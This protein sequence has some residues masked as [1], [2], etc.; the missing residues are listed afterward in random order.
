MKNLKKMAMAACALIGLSLH[1]Q[2]SRADNVWVNVTHL[3][4]NP[5]YATNA[6]TGWTK[7]G[8]GTVACD[9]QTYT[10]KGGT[11]NVSQTLTNVPKG[12]Y[13]V[14]VNAFHRLRAADENNYSTDKDKAATSN[15]YVNTQRKSIKNIY[16]ESL[17]E[18]YHN[19]CWGH[20][21]RGW[22][23]WGGTTYYYP[24]NTESASYMLHS[25][26]YLN[27]ME[28]T[29]R[30]NGNLKIGISNTSSNSGNWT[31]FT[32][33]Q[34]EY[35][36]EV[37]TEG[38]SEV[39][40]N[41]IQSANTDLYMDPSGNYGGWVEI[42]NPTDHF[43]EMK[44]C[45]L[46]DEPGQLKKARIERSC[47]IAPQG[48]AVLWF[49][50]HDQY[51]RSQVNMKLDAD[52]GT[53]YL[54]DEDGTLITSQTY[55]EAISRCS[56]GRT[57]D[58]GQEWGWSATPTPAA[59][60]TG[61]LFSETRLAPP[62]VNHASQIFSGKLQ[63]SVTIPEG[64]VLR[65]TTDGSTP[66]ATHGQ[67]S[68]NGQFSVSSTSIYRFC[69]TGDG[70][71][72]SPVVTRTFLLKDKDFSLPVLSVVSS[73]D[74]LYGDAYGILTKGNGNGRPGYGQSSPCN[75]NMDWERPAHFEYFNEDGTCA[76]SQEVGMTR[77]GG[78]SRAWTPYSFKL[79]AN[80][81]YEHQN[82]MPYDFFPTQKP[83]L[84]HKTLQIRNSGNDAQIYG[85]FGGRIKDAALQQ[86]VMTSG[87]YL[88][89]Q[90]YQPVMHYINGKYMGV[91]NMREPNNKHY[92][93]A[94]YGLDDD[95]IDQFE[96]CADSGYVQ[97]CGTKER[98]NQWYELA[99]HASDPDTYLQIKERVDIDAF[100]N[101]MAVELYLGGDDWPHNNIKG[102]C[103]RTEG[104]KWKFIL[105][106]LDHAFNSSTPISRLYN[107]RKHTFASLYG[108]DGD[109][110]DITGQQQT[111][112]IE[113]ATIFFN[114]LRNADFR[115]QFIDTFCLVAGS[116][117]EPGRVKEIVTDLARRV[118]KPM[119]IANGYN[120]TNGPWTTANAVISKLSNRA[121]TMISHLKSYSG[122][123]LSTVTARTVKLGSNL[124]L[125]RLYVNDLPVP[126][127]KFNGKLFPPYTLRA[128]A[129]EGYRFMGWQESTGNVV[130]TEEVY[131]PATT[132]NLSLTATYVRLTEEEYLAEKG[133]APAPVVINEISAANS[134]YIN[135]Y[136]KK[137]DWI[138]LYNTT[139]E[140][141]DL[142]GMYLT[143]KTDNP[144]KY[145][146]S[147]K[148]AEGNTICSTLLPAHGY[149]VIWCSKREGVSQLHANF[150]LENEEG[151]M[152][153]IQDE[154]GTW[155]DSLSYGL[156]QG[157]QTMG[158]YPDGGEQTYL[159]VKP[160]I[161]ASNTLTSL[162]TPW[163][164]QPGDGLDGIR[165]VACANGLHLSY[166][167]QTLR[168]RSEDNPDITIHVCN[169]MGQTV[170]LQEK[171]L[172]GMTETTLSTYN[173][174]IGTYIAKVTDKEGNESSI[175][176]RKE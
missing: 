70:A 42:Y 140:D 26:M 89:C 3:L 129:P 118:E 44:G 80:K 51:A 173:L 18:N 133:H 175:K 68:A 37:T 16:S 9:F 145:R 128:S 104:G 90:A 69:L 155:A 152:V 58:G 122:M 50:N 138:E 141:I 7:T 113:I 126:T 123:K 8:T 164:E 95:E 23:G 67:T 98:F 66:T 22:W 17:S 75:W 114:M 94:N 41:E 134:I 93:Y 78:W 137:D 154:E 144:R 165:W 46:S 12:K 162:C 86:V 156:Q 25:G 5:Q 35:Y 20:T 83:Y 112:E 56:F 72:T 65:Y 97:K 117:F 43:I 49:D 160:S 125:A 63:V 87:L 136:G 127:G 139:D 158:R 132:K 149:K 121:S 119:A 61:M 60:N 48:H 38:R 31:A 30:A 157:D 77:C 116:V 106:D 110:N 172:D 120:N 39:L 91:I 57:T 167:N 147:G 92:V 168:V 151:A 36:A 85:D 40:I 54:S 107:E 19:G 96:M 27:Q 33:W 74:N 29:L 24:D 32:G 148:D 4:Q 169:A 81:K 142:E 135:E 153:R 100:I 76:F 101:Y 6:S 59:T 124:P 102:W 1:S 176:F 103:P 34:L 64:T 170:I 163:T 108:I 15:L 13:R 146:I 161:L 47:A 105:F 115:K 11:W 73:P 111:K 109:G 28:Y 2:E 62:E 159:M 99:K 52:G 166:A 84:K 79:K 82:S 10:V 130:S 150:K 171:H 55:P 45:W 21:E 174:P 53:L 131:T 14:S 88:D 71:L 143:D